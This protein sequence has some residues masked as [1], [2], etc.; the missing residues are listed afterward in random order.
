MDAKIKDN[1]KKTVK[2]WVAIGIMA[3]LV[4]IYSQWGVYH[5]GYSFWPF[6]KRKE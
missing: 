3:V 1:R 2:E 6:I 4:I 5:L